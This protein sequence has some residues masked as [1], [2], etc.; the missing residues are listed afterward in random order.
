M[1]GLKL[2]RFF[3]II[4]NEEQT[5][6]PPFEIENALHDFSLRVFSLSKPE[7][8]LIDAYREINSTIIEIELMVLKKKAG[9]LSYNN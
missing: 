4:A 9:R 5:Q 7:N 6:L 3:V 2:T 1:K 8:D